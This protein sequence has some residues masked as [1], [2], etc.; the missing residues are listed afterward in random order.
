MTTECTQVSFE[1]QPLRNREIP[2]Y[3]LKGRYVGLRFRAGSVTNPD[4]QKDVPVNVP[5][6]ACGHRRADDCFGDR[7]AHFRRSDSVPHSR[8]H[9]RCRRTLGIVNA[10]RTSRQDGRGL[11]GTSDR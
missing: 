6:G 10:E 4:V 7:V 5:V 1:S 8:R 9:N 2:G 11:T 3:N